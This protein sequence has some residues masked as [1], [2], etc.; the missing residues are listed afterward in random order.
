MDKGVVNAAEVG[1]AFYAIYRF[2]KVAAYV[3]AVP[4]A[5]VWFMATIS[6]PNG[7]Y[8]H[9]IFTHK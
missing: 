1:L 8:V 7:T 5:F 4:L 6:G 2:N 3:S 9:E